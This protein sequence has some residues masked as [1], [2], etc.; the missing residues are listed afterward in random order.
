[1]D[2]EQEERYRPCDGGLVCDVAFAGVGSGEGSTSS[3]AA[4]LDLMCYPK[5]DQDWSNKM[6]KKSNTSK[7]KSNTSKSGQSYQ[8]RYEA[9]V[10]KEYTKLLSEIA[11]SSPWY[12]GPQGAKRFEKEIAAGGY[13]MRGIMSKGG[14]DSAAGVLARRVSASS[15]DLAS[16]RIWQRKLIQNKRRK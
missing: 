10:A 16:S 8:S 7:S 15:G 3:M 14:Q 5:N 9:R 6:K 1:M 11:A 2:A 13:S 12:A 4:L